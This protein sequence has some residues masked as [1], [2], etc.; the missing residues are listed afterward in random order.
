MIDDPK[1]KNS[2]QNST[3]SAWFISRALLIELVCEKFYQLVKLMFVCRSFPYKRSAEI[4]LW[5]SLFFKASKD[6]TVKKVFSGRKIKILWTFTK[7]WTKIDKNMIARV[8]LLFFIIS[9]VSSSHE[10][11]RNMRI[12][13]GT[14]ARVAQ[15]P[16]AV[17]LALHLTFTRS[18][19]CGGSIIHPSY[20]LTVSV[21]FEKIKDCFIVIKKTRLPFLL[22]TNGIFQE[23]LCP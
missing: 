1:S 10:M 11:D 19:F 8:T 21:K 23:K 20:V 14:V 5:I 4:G 7:F 15:F 16:H 3:N 17:A 9:Q 2:M 13:G 12:V 22:E 18:S 6:G